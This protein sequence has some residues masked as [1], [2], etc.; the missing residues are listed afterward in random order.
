[1][2]L[3]V[4]FLPS[5]VGSSTSSLTL[6]TGNLKLEDSE[7][8]PSYVGCRSVLI[9]PVEVFE[10]KTRVDSTGASSNLI[11]TPEVSDPVSMRKDP[12]DGTSALSLA[13]MAKR[14]N[15]VSMA[16]VVVLIEA[17]VGGSLETVALLS[18]KI[19]ATIV[20][21]DVFSA[22]DSVTLKL[23]RICPVSTR[24]SDLSALMF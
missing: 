22:R 20:P 11:W 19:L 14:E 7:K 12:P 3:T 24:R 13:S 5:P 18:M 2:T 10:V 21:V 15:L 1:M 23:P 4:L 6:T 17:A 16:P 8:V 9:D